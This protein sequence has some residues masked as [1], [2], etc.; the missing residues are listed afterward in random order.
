MKKAALVIIVF[1]LF[2]LAAACS[3]KDSAAAGQ[4]ASAGAYQPGAVEARAVEA[5]GR[6]WIEVKNAD[7]KG[8]EVRRAGSAEKVDDITALRTSVALP[9]GIYDVTFGASVWKN[10]EVK[11]GETIA[12]AAGSLVLKHAALAGHD[13][14]EA[15]TGAVQGRVSATTSNITLIPGKY[16]VRFGPL[17]WLV[18]IRGEETTTLDPGVVTVERAGVQGH[19]ITDAAGKVVGEV[20][21]IMSTIP[22]P[23]GEYVIEIGAEKIPFALKEG[24]RRVFENK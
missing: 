17:S 10:V 7:L 22:L 2:F 4:S 5:A 6:G 23:P 11:A 18:E 24:E 21:N 16:E 13:V 19:R 12:L 15:A 9:A 3:K 1:G 20:S 14:V 8:H